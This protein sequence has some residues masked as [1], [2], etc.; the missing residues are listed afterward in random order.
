MC[1]MKMAKLES[2]LRSALAFKDAFNRHEVAGIL[3]LLSAEC[4]FETSVP[5]PDGAAYRGKEAIARCWQD[6]FDQWPQIRLEVEEVYGFGERCVMRWRWS[7]TGASGEAGHLRGAD[8]FQ[9][10]DDLICEQFSYI[11][12]EIACEQKELP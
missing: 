3:R 10:K 2:A 6:F 12:G 7:W 11:K 8:I 1:P 9:V 5:A 4:L